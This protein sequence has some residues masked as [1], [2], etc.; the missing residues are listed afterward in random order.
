MAAKLTQ[1]RDSKNSLITLAMAEQGNF[2]GSLKCDVCS[3]EVE[4]IRRYPRNVG[5]N[6]VQV[7]SF[8][9]L[10]KHK[11]H[12]VDCP[13]DVLGQVKIIAR[14]S[15]PSILAGINA[16]QYDFRLLAVR[17]A[18]NDLKIEERKWLNSQD[19]EPAKQKEYLKAQQRLSGYLNSAARVL[20]LRA[21]CE[22]NSQIEEFIK[23]SFDGVKL[24]WK[25]FYYEDE[26]YFRCLTNVKKATV[27]V[28]MAVKGTIKSIKT[29]NG[30]K[31]PLT[32][33]NL[34]SPYRKTDKPN[35]VET[36]ALSVWINGADMFKRYRAEQDVL[37][38]GIWELANESEST[39][40]RQGV[41]DTIFRNLQLRLWI[42]TLSQVCLVR[43]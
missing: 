12:A 26:D 19:R 28:P 18:I 25:D 40:R 1:A 17:K 21:A 27:A 10:K 23:L 38:F 41:P 22:E 39:S 11:M 29:I 8:F 30:H 6:I 2:S 24:S 34:V 31:G 9:R 4:F 36:A 3:V 14:E 15:D 37:A 5:D 33:M 42:I 13:H 16:G 7:K 35:V 32:V 20:K 43:D